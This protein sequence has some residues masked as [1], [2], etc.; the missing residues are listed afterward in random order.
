MLKY[1]G[2][3]T[4]SFWGK[5]SLI[6]NAFLFLLIYTMLFQRFF[7]KYFVAGTIFTSVTFIRACVIAPLWEEIAFRYVPMKLA[8]EKY[9]L[10]VMVGSSIY[11]GL[12]HGGIENI[13]IQGVAGMVLCCVYI[14][15]NYSIWVNMTLHALWNAFVMFIVP[16]YAAP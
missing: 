13:F 6:G 2:K 3:R 1:L 16:F 15:S 7:S 8:G 11:F 4:D 14:K 9:M 12:Q 10:P 5:V